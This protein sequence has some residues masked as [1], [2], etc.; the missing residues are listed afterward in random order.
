MWHFLS[1]EL[2]L[3][4]PGGWGGIQKVVLSSWSAS[5]SLGD[6]EA[7]QL[8]ICTFYKLLGESEDHLPQTMAPS[9]SC[10]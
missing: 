8:G 9:M 3:H 5:V 6:S 4:I 10:K 1:V 7:I 2:V